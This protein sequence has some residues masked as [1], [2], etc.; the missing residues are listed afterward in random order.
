MHNERIERL[1]RDVH[2]SVIVT[3][4]NLFRA[5]ES[6]EHLDH[7]NEVHIYCLHYIFLPRINQALSSFVEGWNNH[8]VSTEHHQT[9]YQMYLMGM[10]PDLED[11]SS[12]DSESDSECG[13]SVDLQCNEAVCVP[14][15]SF[16]PCQQLR[17]ELAQSVGVTS[18]CN[19]QGKSLF[20]RAIAICGNHLTTG[21]V[22]CM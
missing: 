10:L 19:D 1:W 17:T 2:R 20:L 22:Q 15:C 3:F 7:L 18:A 16:T 6:E 4:G 11:S 9:P 5:L 8:S 21:C 12:N 13:T 14:R